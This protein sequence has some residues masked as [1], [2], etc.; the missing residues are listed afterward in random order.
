[1][2]KTNT[3]L[4]CGFWNYIFLKYIR[5]PQHPAKIRCIRF[6]GKI[7]FSNG[8]SLIN[9]TGAHFNAD[10]SQFIGWQILASGS[11]EPETIKRGLNILS[12]GG[13][14]VDVGAN[15]G[16]HLACWG[17]LP[18]VTS[19]AIEPLPSNFF[20]LKV[21]AIANTTGTNNL[22]NIAV[23]D[24]PELL[25]L[26][27]IDPSNNGKTRIAVNLP[28]AQRGQ[29]TVVAAF[30]LEA[31]ASHAKVAGISLL[32][33]DVEGYELPVLR[34]LNWNGAFRPKNVIIE[35]SDYCARIEGSGRSTIFEFFEQNGYAAFS[36]DGQRLLVDAAPL[37]D[38]AWFVDLKLSNG[39][40]SLV[41]N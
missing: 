18:G 7:F 23:S 27:E 32:K 12:G 14:Y 5:G 13:V 22:F 8:V 1:M 21:V 25:D 3:W 10:P 2:N 35:Y 30:P 39:D 11:Y 41:A 19:I 26:E 40:D 29:T 31:I 17:C 20:K 33:I 36:V 6:I 37:E 15:V 16:L 9:K 34:S 38:N 24:K 28:K 4:P